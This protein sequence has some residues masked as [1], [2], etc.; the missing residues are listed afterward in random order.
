MNLE[1]PD[2]AWWS[3][4][5]QQGTASI[6]HVDL[7]ENQGREARALD[8]LNRQERIRADR[9]KVARARR[10]FVL[11]R[12]ALRANLCAKTGCDNTA[13]QFVA[14]ERGK[15]SALVDGQSLQYQFNLSHSRS[16]GLLAFATEGQLGVDVEDWDPRRPIDGA[17]RR[18]FSEAEQ[19]AL[20]QTSPDQ[21]RRLFFRLWTLK[22]A[23]IKA[24][25]EGFRRETDKFSVPESLI[26]GE[27][28]AMF[29]FE[30]VPDI[31]W[32][33]VNLESDRFAAALAHEVIP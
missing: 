7:S 30:D 9:F 22:E 33:L 21:R 17:I 11:C 24:T 1:Q 19:L 6:V 28:T 23:L 12:A 25:G 16:H 3:C 31:E 27:R 14:S 20:Q 18:V 29:R 2:D 26:Q 8:W 32:N 10:A 5:S 4:F 13:L 15:L